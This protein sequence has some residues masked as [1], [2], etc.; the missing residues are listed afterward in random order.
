[1]ERTNLP[2][3]FA[4]NL[5]DAFVRAR[6][7]LEQADPFVL[8]GNASVGYRALSPET[9]EFY[10]PY[11]REMHRVRFPEA[12][13]WLS[14]WRLASPVTHILLLHY[15]LT[16][17]GTLP[18]GQWVT[19]RQLPNAF[20]Y[21]QAFTQRATLPLA[22]AFARDLEGFRRGGL[23]AGG[24]P[25]RTADASFY[26]RV[27]PHLPMMVQLWVADED[28]PASANILFDAHAGH[29][30]PTEDLSGIGGILSRRIIQGAQPPSV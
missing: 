22:Q 11:F 24:E 14:P 21:D 18:S 28:L 7:D 10:L 13:V 5:A 2:P 20:P 1:M 6:Y 26:F 30:L 23:A 29:Q 15:L 9:G 3:G 19:F 12:T 25:A 8:A 27:L 17:D 16:A 4:G